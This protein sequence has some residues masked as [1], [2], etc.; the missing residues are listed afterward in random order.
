MANGL[1][2]DG[3]GDLFFRTLGVMERRE[4]IKV[5]SRPMGKKK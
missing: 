2:E 3:K 5:A 4:N 1:T